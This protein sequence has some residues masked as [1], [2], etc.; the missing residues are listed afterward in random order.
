M[1]PGLAADGVLAANCTSVKITSA[2]NA[3]TLRQNC[4][5]V[6]GT[7]TIGPFYESGNHDINLDGVKV[8]QG[9]FQT[10]ENGFSPGAMPSVPFTISSSTLE[11]V[12]GDITFYHNS[13]HNVSLPNLTTVHKD[14][15]V[16]ETPV[17]Y[18]DNL[19]TLHHTNLTNASVVEVY[20]MLLDSVHSV[21][22]NAINISQCT[23]KGPFPNMDTITVGFTNVS[24]ELY[25]S[26][27]LNVTLGG[28]ST[29]KMDLEQFELVGNS[30]GLM[31]SSTLDS[32]TVNRFKVINSLMNRL[33]VDFDD[34]EYLRVW[35][36]YGLEEIQLPPKAV[37]WTG[38]LNLD[39]MANEKVNL[40]SQ[41]A[42]DDAG[43][44][45][46]TW[47]W[48]TNVSSIEI[49]DSLLG[50][51]L[52][53]TF[54]AQEMQPLNRTPTPSILDGFTISPNNNSVFNCTPFDTLRQMGRLTGDYQ[55]VNYSSSA[56][57]AI[58]VPSLTTVITVVF[59]L[60]ILS[61]F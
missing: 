51:A 41:Y 4:P 59:G 14:F 18:L 30:T 55:C 57:S 12:E 52:F 42:I 61:T 2:S 44:Q 24:Q 26:A 1:G 16:G 22:K 34:L 38:G 25:I 56:G 40:T 11:L 6:S 50:N 35:S 27:A 23:V 53:D 47:Y 37:D 48:P 46:Q 13:L 39:I 10:A 43:N 31:R 28:S 60:A 3:E 33:Y 36:N 29:T 8:I 54:L 17:T 7:V 5:T 15:Y 32:L 9:D 45:I 20:P 49:S 58:L 21:L 19:T